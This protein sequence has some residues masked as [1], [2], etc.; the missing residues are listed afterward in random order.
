MVSVLINI[1]ILI[2][3]LRA[4][5]LCWPGR[6]WKLFYFYTQLSNMITAVS[7]ALL[8]AAGPQDWVTCLRYLSTCMLI[9]TFFVTTCVLIPM[10]GDAKTLLFSG[11]GLYLHTLCPCLGTFSYLFLEKHVSWSALP[12]PVT[13]TLI[14]GLTM[15]LLNALRVTDGPYPFFRVHEQSVPRTVLWILVQ[16]AVISAISC[17]VILAGR[18]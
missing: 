3:E 1:L 5:F 2:L 11:T 7:C 9:M 14:Y 6:K 16:M 17:L 12:I 13:V 4:L 10:G 18:P 8:L 15:L